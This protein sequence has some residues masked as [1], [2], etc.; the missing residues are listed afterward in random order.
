MNEVVEGRFDEIGI[1]VAGGLYN[2]LNRA[3]EH[4]GCSDVFGNTSL[5]MYIM[6]VAYPVVDAEVIRF[7]QRQEG[8]A[9]GGGGPAGLPGTEYQHHPETP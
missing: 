3:M 1:I 4:V 6:N 5:P 8:G 2:T 7:C 9:H